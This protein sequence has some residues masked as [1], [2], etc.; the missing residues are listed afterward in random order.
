M[1]FVKLV[2]FNEGAFVR[3]KSNFFVDLIDYDSTRIWN[4]I[5]LI[6]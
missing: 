3:W 4:P 2:I 6:R 5:I 1:Q